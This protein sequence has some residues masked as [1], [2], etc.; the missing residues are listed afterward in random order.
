MSSSDFFPLYTH[1]S[2]IAG[3]INLAVL[4]NKLHLILN[5]AA[6][7]DQKKTICYTYYKS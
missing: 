4:L 2:K 7:M 1:H 6:D 3:N 5:S